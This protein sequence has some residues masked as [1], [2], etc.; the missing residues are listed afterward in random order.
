MK[1]I[2]FAKTIYTYTKNS[3]IS[4]FSFLLI[5]VIPKRNISEVINT[6]KNKKVLVLG[7]GPSLNNLNQNLIDKYDIVFFLNGAISVSKVYF[8]S[9]KN[10]ISGVGSVMTE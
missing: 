1:Y 6:F 9:F 5:K 3:F 4:I 10:Y 8:M 2:I 7:T